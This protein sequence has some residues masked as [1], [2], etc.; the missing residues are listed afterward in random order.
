MVEWRGLVV[1]VKLAEM[2]AGMGQWGKGADNQTRE[3]PSSADPG[4]GASEVS[5][6]CDS[7]EKGRKKGGGKTVD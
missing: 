4:P 5:T 7:P 2:D 6:T 3:L 1:R